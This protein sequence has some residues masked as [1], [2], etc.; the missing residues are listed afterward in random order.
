[1]EKVLINVKVLA[2]PLVFVEGEA[3]FMSSI[4]NF[5]R[6]ETAP[7]MQELLRRK[8]IRIFTD[9]LVDLAFTNAIAENLVRVG[10]NITG[11]SVRFFFVC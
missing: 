7:V 11:F 1:M 3:S 10:R 6:H 4:Y 9:C 2:R 8:N 5:M